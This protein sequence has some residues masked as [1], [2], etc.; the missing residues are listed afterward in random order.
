MIECTV[1]RVACSRAGRDKG[2][3]AIIVAIV[4]DQYVLVADGSLRKLASPK[5]KKLKHLFLRPQE[6][7]DIG[8]KLKLG[9]RVFDHELRNAL[10]EFGYIEDCGS[11]K[12]G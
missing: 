10:R 1:G 5:K 4:D 7:K 11:I 6:A 8:D 2:R 9:Q 3:Y 12:E